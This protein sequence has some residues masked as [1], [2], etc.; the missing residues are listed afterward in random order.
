M[1]DLKSP[2]PEWHPGAH[3][4]ILYT[5]ASRSAG[6]S[7]LVVVGP[8]TESPDP[9]YSALEHASPVLGRRATGVLTLL[10]IVAREQRLAWVYEYVDGIGAT[11]LA[12]DEGSEDLPLGTA[13]QVVA[14]V[15]QTLLNLGPLGVQHPGPNL[16]DILIDRRGGV[17]VGGFVSP[18]PPDPV[19]REPHGHTDSPATVYRLGILLSSLVCGAPPV[20]SSDEKAH[21]AMVRRVLIRAVARPGAGFTERYRECLTAMVSW[22]PTKRPPLSTIPAALNEIAAATGDP[23]LSAWSARMVSELQARVADPTGDDPYDPWQ[24]SDR[25]W[26]QDEGTPKPVSNLQLTIPHEQLGDLEDED[27]ATAESAG[28]PPVPVGRPNIPSDLGVIPVGVGPPAEAIKDIPKLPEGFLGAEAPPEPPPQ[29]QV[30]EPP[31]L[32]ERNWVRLIAI[33]TVL[34]VLGLLSMVYLFLP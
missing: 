15:A 13:A 14:T 33:S 30:L 31:P 6:Q 2:F 34:L 24:Q 27:E 3:L 8:E 4:G 18:F 26:T 5:D 29:P 12:N 1:V 25:E 22:D 19:L 17:H 9:L 32:T 23:S 20:A 11:W 10:A 16:D 28:R 7:V 21:Q